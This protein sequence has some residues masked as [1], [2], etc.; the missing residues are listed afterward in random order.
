MG[1]DP[2][3]SGIGE[4]SL[5]K[6]GDARDEAASTNGNE[7]C[8]DWTRMLADDLHCDGALAGD[9]VRVVERMNE[10]QSAVLCE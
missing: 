1:L 6:H 10:S 2:D 5:E 4:Q 8:V 9:D 7:D 3:Y